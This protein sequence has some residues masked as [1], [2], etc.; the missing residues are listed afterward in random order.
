MAAAKQR[1]KYAPPPTPSDECKCT[2][3]S[4][5]KDFGTLTHLF[6]YY[7]AEGIRVFSR[8]RY[9]IA[10]P[11]GFTDNVDKTFRYCHHY[12]RTNPEHVAL[13][14]GLPRILEA[15]AKRVP[16]MYLVEGCPDCE[17]A[18]ALADVYATTTHLGTRFPMEVAEHFRGYAGTVYILVDR[19]H[20]D[21]EHQARFN[22]ED[23][24]K[25]RDYPGSA[26]ALRRWRALRTVGVKAFFREAI[27][28]KDLRDH[29]E[30]G[31]TIAQLKKVPL[32]TIRARAPR[33][34]ENKRSTTLQLSV[35][36]MPEGPGMARFVKALEAKGFC[37]EKI[38]P[39]RYKTNCPHPDHDDHNPSFEFEQGDKGVVMTC[40]S[41]Q[42]NY[43]KEGTKKI[44]E[45][46]GIRVYDLF[47]SAKVKGET[48]P[49]PTETDDGRAYSPDA[50]DPMEVAR[51]IADEFV[52]EDDS[53]TLM[54]SDEDFW[55]YT[56][57]H[58][59]SVK[60]ARIESRLYKRMDKEFVLK[61]VDGEWKPQRWAP[62]SGKISNLTDAVQAT[63]FVDELPTFN[64][65]QDA[66]PGAGVFVPMK[67]GILHV[68]EAVLRPSTPRYF[69]TWSL[70]FDY[71]PD[72]TCPDWIAFLEDVFE[73][74]PESIL[75][76]QQFFGYVISGRTDLEKI[77]VVIGPSRSGKGTIAEV[78]EVMVG[79][80]NYEGFTLKSLSGEF[81]LQNLVGKSVMVDS[82]ARSA[83]KAE[84]MQTAIERLLSLS[85]NDKVIVNR[86]NKLPISVRLGIRPVIMSN[87][88]PAFM[89]SSNAIN[90]RMMMIK[91]R[92]SFLG[93]EDPTLKPRVKAEIQGV[94]NWALEGLAKLEE[95]GRFIQP[96]SASNYIDT[97]QEGAS[98]HEQFIRQFCVVGEVGD[99]E[100]WCHH[101]HLVQLW[102]NYCD[103]NDMKPGN[104]N[105]L[106]R[107][108]AP[109]VTRLGG[110]MGKGFRDVEG[111]S[112]RVITGI[113]IN[114]SAADG[115]KVKAAP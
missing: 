28:G 64:A 37:L 25:R 108:L 87:E 96:A 84:D 32:E 52:F 82:D 103:H 43:G 26:S 107:K 53:E 41:G 75:L 20:L 91:M 104:P 56:G 7:N 21:P 97:L 57:T 2:R 55:V 76:L 105:W 79:P 109:I 89:D 12:D 85:A 5:Q 74:D 8:F 31:K 112:V 90:D 13:I 65:W 102:K 39:T 34:S 38:G 88:L 63:H 110:E 45:F 24:D 30:A 15:K 86:K 70:P 11:S 49:Q 92:K 73:D 17:A 42:C 9:T 83:L 58:W 10:D 35:A 61:L 81:G 113:S 111:E 98:P 100:S 44:C 68:D 36:D 22:H 114:E 69:S 93:K 78:L 51:H 54:F 18:W 59:E 99:E 48:G 67:N 50:S 95:S 72:A 6:P 80:R 94:L 40:E 1:A 27:R 71:D 3:A 66:A 46:L 4:S 77:L 16:H 115:P 14:Y 106:P 29:L 60:K 19:D 62:T 47:D 101:A 33:E 23:E